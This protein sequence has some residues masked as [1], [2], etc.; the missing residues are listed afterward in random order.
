MHL[1]TLP[2]TAHQ[3]LLPPSLTAEGARMG[4]EGGLRLL[5]AGLG[6]IWEMPFQE[7]SELDTLWRGLSNE[8]R[9][10]ASRRRPR[11]RLPFETSRTQGLE[12]HVELHVVRA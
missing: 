7:V 9:P 6:Q 12:A 8:R 10:V 1:E 5:A 2:S 3:K 4:T 11:T